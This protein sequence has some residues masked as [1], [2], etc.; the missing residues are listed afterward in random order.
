M[1]KE[2]SGI[3]PSILTVLLFGLLSLAQL[4]ARQTT[5]NTLAKPDFTVREEMIPMRDGTRLYTLILS[6]KDAAVP[7]PVLL[8]RTPYNASWRLLNP[9]VSSLKELLG[10][11]FMGQNY[12]YVFQD[13]RGRFKSEG[14]YFM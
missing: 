5:S 14:D 1:K 9:D 2:R 12:I 13:I 4:Q 8:L 6:P 10:T 3:F 11:Q 7:L